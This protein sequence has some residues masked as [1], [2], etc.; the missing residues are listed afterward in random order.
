MSI[1]R[2]A[3]GIDEARVIE[4]IGEHAPQGSSKTIVIE[5]PDYESIQIDGAHP[6][7][8]KVLKM[9]VRRPSSGRYPFLVGP[10][11]S[12]K[13]FL[14]SQLAKA[15][16]LPMYSHAFAPI[17]QDHLFT[18]FMNAMGEYVGTAFRQWAQFGGIFL[19]DEK[20]RGYASTLVLLNDALANRR[21]TFPDGVTVE[22]HPDAHWISAGNT[23]GLGADSRYVTA[24]V[25]DQS[26]LDRFDV[27]NVNYDESVEVAMVRSTGVDSATADRI[28]ERVARLRAVIANQ[29]LN[30]LLSPRASRAIAAAIADGE[31]HDDAWNQSFFA[32]MDA[33][34]RRKLLAI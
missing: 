13:S 5:R 26:T 28:L 2:D 34:T 8:E 3:I 29:S 27:V 19:G 17:P 25:L 9:L 1:L 10:A 7:F 30:V 21:F 22:F 33:D 6:L 4:L 31:D 23:L 32:K 16:D 20:D 18:G 12:G 15:L 14:A 11:G 24:Q